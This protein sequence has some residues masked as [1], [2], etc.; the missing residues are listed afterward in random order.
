MDYICIQE[1]RSV[2]HGLE[3]GRHY[4]NKEHKRENHETYEWIW[5]IENK[6]STISYNKYRY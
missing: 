3:H 4:V 2:A 5:D 1:R 6:D